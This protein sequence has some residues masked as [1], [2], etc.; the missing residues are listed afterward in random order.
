MVHTWELLSAPWVKLKLGDA[1]FTVIYFI[2]R[3]HKTDETVLAKR[4]MYPGI[5][6]MYKSQLSFCR[7]CG[8]SEASGQQPP[9]S[10]GWLRVAVQSR[11]RCAGAASEDGISLVER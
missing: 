4:A 5:N 10:P 7:E 8:G 3:N 1:T 2:W 11:A 9:C 6:G